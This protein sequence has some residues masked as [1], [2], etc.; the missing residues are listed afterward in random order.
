MIVYSDE[1]E[2]FLKNYIY[3]WRRRKSEQNA[4]G[5]RNLAESLCA[6]IDFRSAENEETTVGS[7]TIEKELFNLKDKLR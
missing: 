5:I 3:L 4:V 6:F 1:R 7:L 2:A